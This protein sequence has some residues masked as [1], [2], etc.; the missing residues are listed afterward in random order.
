MTSIRGKAA[1]LYIGPQADLKTKASNGSYN[2]TYMYD[3]DPGG[4]RPFEADPILGG[5]FFNSRD[6]TGPAPGLADSSV[7]LTAPSCMNHLAYWLKAAMGAPAI[8]GTAPVLRKFESGKDTLPAHTL[9]VELASNDG[10]RVTGF[11]LDKLGFTIGRNAGFGKVQVEGAARKVEPV[12][13][14]DVGSVPAAKALTR[15][16]AYRGIF[17]IDSVAQATLL[18]A[19]AVYSNNLDLVEYATDDEFIGDICPGDSDFKIQ[20]SVRYKNQFFANKAANAFSNTG[21]FAGEWEWQDGAGNSL[22]LKA[23]V[24]R[25][26]SASESISGPGGIEVSYNITAEQSTTAPMLTAELRNT[27]ASG[28]YI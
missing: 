2:N 18:S 7:K 4:A 21:K 27:I 22:I 23:P 16:A 9:A 14:L 1:K 26:E 20:I 10:R 5:V 15:S 28:G 8:S 13:N 12:T 24:C 17:R 6:A 11:V 25:V 3:I 19:S